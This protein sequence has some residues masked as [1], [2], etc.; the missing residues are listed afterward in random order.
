M[1]PSRPEPV[2]TPARS[3]RVQPAR[4]S[5]AQPA[6]TV[7]SPGPAPAEHARLTF[8]GRRAKDTRSS[9]AEGGDPHVVREV[10]PLPMSDT[11]HRRALQLALVCAV[12][13][14]LTQGALTHLVGTP[15]GFL[16]EVYVTPG[17]EGEPRRTAVVPGISDDRLQMDTA[18]D[19]QFSVR[20]TADWYAPRSGTYRISGGADDR[21]EVLVDGS[22]VLERSPERG[23]ETVAASVTLPRGTHRLEV[24]FQQFRGDYFVNLSWAEAGVVEGIDGPLAAGRPFNEAL[25]FPPGTDFSPT[26]EAGIDRFRRLA[27]WLWLVVLVVAA[28]SLALD[29]RKA[30]WPVRE[31]LGGSLRRLGATLAENARHGAAPEAGS[32]QRTLPRLGT[33]AVLALLVGVVVFYAALLRVDAALGKYGFV[34]G[35][36]P[37][38]EIQLQLRMAANELRPEGLDTTFVEEGYGRGD[39]VNYIRFAREMESFYA[40]HIR[41]P[42]FVFSTKASIWLL[43]GQEVGVSYASA[44]YSVLLVWATYLLGAHAFSRW[45]GL[46]AALAVAIE[47]QFVSWGVDGWRDDAF[48][49]FVVLTAWAVLRLRH[50]PNRRNALLAGAVA[51]GA[52]LTRITALSFVVPAFGWALLPLAEGD[53]PGLDFSGISDLVPWAKG[54]GA[55]V[56]AAVL[57]GTALV[58]PYLINCWIVYGDPLWSINHATRFYRGREGLESESYVSAG[59]YLGRMARDA[60]VEFTDTVVNGLTTYPFNN[61]WSGFRPWSRSLARALPVLSLLGLALFLWSWPGRFLLLVGST[62]LL[63]YAFTWRITGGAAWRFTMHVYPLLLIAAFWAVHEAW[64]FGKLMLRESQAPGTF[65]RG[66]FFR[67][68]AATLA[69]TGGL[70]LLL[71]ELPHLRLRENLEQGAPAH[72]RA[73]EGDDRYFVDGWHPPVAGRNVTARW[74][75]GDRGTLTLPMLAGRDH[76]LI[77]RLSPVPAGPLAAADGAPSGDTASQ[78]VTVSLNGVTVAEFDLEWDP[79]RVGSYEVEVPG[80]IVRD[81]NR[82]TLQGS[83]VARTPPNPAVP[84]VPADRRVGFMVWYVNVVPLATGR[85]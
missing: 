64:R 56:L 55:V 76:R 34:E 37:G 26:L 58:S 14:A 85:G 47:R 77:L 17:F 9:R 83:R 18:L 50:R 46:A 38:P 8:R 39:P 68:T 41:E 29:Q 21:L 81:S 71:R 43:G 45:V 53:R 27:P 31:R 11:S 66:P 4:R 59:E 48:S 44:F 52:C 1:P 60:P 78:V 65:A 10:T 67:R 62:S 51:A 63:P 30:G 7:E 75:D 79:S 15:R 69:L 13:L 32:P 70:A 23:F 24:L 33:R 74:T 5:H 6:R 2:P 42:L 49:F 28:W 12:A 84:L 20:W 73:G 36:P 22:T 35:V 82:L 80:E 72:I 16:E 57:V 40:A 19:R 25:I 54:R 61:K 3:S